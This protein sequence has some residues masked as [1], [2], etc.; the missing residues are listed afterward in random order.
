MRNAEKHKPHVNHSTF[1]N[2]VTPN[3]S[4]RN[5]QKSMTKFLKAQTPDRPKQKRKRK[6]PK[7]KVQKNKNIQHDQ[8]NPK[9]NDQEGEEEEEQKRAPPVKNVQD[10]NGDVEMEEVP[11]PM[12]AAP[13]PSESPPP[14][15]EEKSDEI[16]AKTQKP[17][18]SIV[19]VTE[20][21]RGEYVRYSQLTFILSLPGCCFCQ[22]YC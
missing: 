6:Q 5:F 9:E 7:Q 1:I 21:D 17:V 20:N 8:Q 4:L 16:N 14:A 19:V 3:P 12:E 10:M 22:N 2:H 13:D 18:S 15:L 11:D